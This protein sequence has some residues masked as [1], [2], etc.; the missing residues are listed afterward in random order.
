MLIKNLE[1]GF[2]QPLRKC[3]R[4]FDQAPISVQA[5]MLDLSYNVGT[6]AACKSTAVKRLADK[7]WRLA[8]HA[9]TAFDRAGCKAVEGLRKRRE[10]DDSKRIGELELCLVALE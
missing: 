10:M 5:S 1:A 2:R 8:Y 6:G 3:I 9:M 4:T 7:Q